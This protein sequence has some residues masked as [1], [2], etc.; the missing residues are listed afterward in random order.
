MDVGEVGR[1]EEAPGGT[2]LSFL[3]GI[4]YVLQMFLALFLNWNGSLLYLVSL[5]SRKRADKHVNFEHR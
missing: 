5:S 4:I 2:S 1:N 3:T